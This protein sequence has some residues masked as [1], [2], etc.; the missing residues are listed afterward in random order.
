MVEFRFYAELGDF[1]APN[2]RGRCFERAVAAHQSVKHAIEALGVPHTEVGLVLVNGT[3][4]AMHCRLSPDD[5]VAVLPTLHRLAPPSCME[6]RKGRDGPRF[7]ADAHLARLAR[8][9]R[10][11]GFDTLWHNA[12]ADAELVAIAARE[13]RIILTRDRDLLMHRAVDAGCYVRG[14]EPLAQLL[15]VAWRYTLDIGG[16]ERHGRCLE[17]NVELA[18]VSRSEVA[19]RL[20]PGTLAGFSEFWCCPECRRVFWRGSHWRRMRAALE[21]VAR[22]LASAH[23][24]DSDDSG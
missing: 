4:V 12:W 3:P 13:Q 16:G 11:A 24:T 6:R 14:E 8:Y 15:D 20:L 17:C 21:A 10:F 7:V 2:L 22:Q 19:A 1:L 18:T 23:A 5:R 9:L